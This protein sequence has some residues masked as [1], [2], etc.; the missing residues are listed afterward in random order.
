[1][2]AGAVKTRHPLEWKGMALEPT[3]PFEGRLPP[4]TNG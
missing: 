1:M 4:V 2:M 3:V